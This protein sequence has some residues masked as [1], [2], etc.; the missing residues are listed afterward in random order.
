VSTDGY[1]ARF[2][3]WRR[4]RPFWGGLL[5]V[6]SGLELFASA[7]LTL[8]GIEIHLGPQGFLSYLIPLLTLICGVLT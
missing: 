5:L 7:N 2:R 4:G 1:W 6:L 8:G 3:L